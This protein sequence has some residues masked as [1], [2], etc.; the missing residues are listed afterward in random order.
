ML[1]PV[2][3]EGKEKPC[4]KISFTGTVENLSDPGKQI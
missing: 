4:F 2:G 1:K 3:I